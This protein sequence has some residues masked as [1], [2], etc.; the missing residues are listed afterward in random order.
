[1]Q[2]QH[3]HFSALELHRLKS[4]EL[5]YSRFIESNVPLTNI[6]GKLELDLYFKS[7][8]RLN[9]F[10]LASHEDKFFY[11][12]NYDPNLKRLSIDKTQ[13]RVGS[14]YQAE[15]PVLMQRKNSHCLLKRENREQLVWSPSS[16]PK[17]CEKYFQNALALRQT[18]NARFRHSINDTPDTIKY[19]ALKLL[20]QSGHNKALALTVITKQKSE[21]LMQ[22]HGNRRRKSDETATTMT[23]DGNEFAGDDEER[24]IAEQ[25]TDNDVELFA[26]GIDKLGK[27]FNEIKKKYLPNKSLKSIIEYYYNNWK[28][29]GEYVA[30]RNEKRKKYDMQKI[31]EVNL[32]QYM[33]KFGNKSIGIGMGTK[34]MS[35]HDHYSNNS[36]SSI[37]NNNNG[38]SSKP[39]ISVISNLATTIATP[40]PPTTTNTNLFLNKM[41]K[42]F[43]CESCKHIKLLNFESNALMSSTG[44]PSFSSSSTSSSSPQ[45]SSNNNNSNNKSSSGDLKDLSMKF[46]LK[47]DST[48][49]NHFSIQQPRILL[50]A[51]DKQAISSLLKNNSELI[52]S[53]NENGGINGRINSKTNTNLI[54]R[55]QQQQQQQQSTNATTTNYSHHFYQQHAL[56][57]LNCNLCNDCWIYWKKYAILKYNPTDLGETEFFFI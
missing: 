47:K 31:T 21:Y 25:W 27:E 34:H 23:N 20:Q 6:R 45:P 35:N 30:N 46:I 4:R 17:S 13:I 29:S 33:S 9:D 22:H 28:T 15:I 37:N 14:K 16:P 26:D 8:H 7:I 48:N 51:A 10:L 40:P 57:T 11:Q 39:S 53:N 49:S 12:F 44:S 18:F 42:T 1:M 41:S 24:R 50:T 19:E 38:F 43:V 54:V 55:P 32:S 3:Q 2:H 52:N 5:F 56:K 36:S